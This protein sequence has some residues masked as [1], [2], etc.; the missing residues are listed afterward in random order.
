MSSVYDLNETSVADQVKITKISLDLHYKEI[1]DQSWNF[2]LAILSG[3]FIQLSGH[4]TICLYVIESVIQKV[5]SYQ[6]RGHF[7]NRTAGDICGNKL[8]SYRK[9][10][11]I[12]ITLRKT[13]KGAFIY[14]YFSIHWDT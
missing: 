2:Y 1:P 7:Y 14:L 9:C 13:T 5:V 6:N 8:K 10:G 12:L 3:M 4:H 11:K